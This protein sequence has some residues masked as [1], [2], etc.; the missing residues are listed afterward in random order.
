MVGRRHNGKARI[1][2][3]AGLALIGFM[4]FGKYCVE[5]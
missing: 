1:L 4:G 3:R 5:S 2:A